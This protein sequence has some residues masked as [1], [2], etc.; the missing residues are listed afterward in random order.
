MKPSSIGDQE[1]KLLQYINNHREPLSVREVAEDYGVSNGLARTTILT[2]M[3][4]L[5][6]KGYLERKKMGRINKYSPKLSKKQ[7]L[8]D[9]VKGFVENVLEGSISPFVSYL[10]H[11]AE[12]NDEEIEELKKLIVKLDE[13]EEG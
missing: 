13:K 2:M 11:E 10:S 8:G 4:R 9:L 1:L 6:D 7:L 5:R 3:E 12:L